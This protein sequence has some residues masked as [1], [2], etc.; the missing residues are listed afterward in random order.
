M[1]TRFEKVITFIPLI[2]NETKLV[3]SSC[4]GLLALMLCY[5]FP[6]VT[7]KELCFIAMM[8]SFLGDVSLNC[9]PLEKRPHS[10]LYTG[11]GFFMIAHLVYASAYYWMIKQE[12]LSIFNHGAFFA[13]VF[14]VILYMLTTITVVI[15]KK[16]PNKM[17]IFIFSLY[18]IVI[19]I[20]FV[21][22]CSYSYLFGSVSFIGALSFLVSDFIIGIETLFK[23][24]SDTLRKLVWIFYPIGQ[25][26]I[27]VCR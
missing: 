10:L 26:L 22:I 6:E 23:I 4:L 7:D 17:V 11:A 2:S 20:N 18:T 19:G 9:K 16:I 1:K 25:F 21:T 13:I 3:I 12:S 8:F 27:I 15:A 24:K 5:A 14:M